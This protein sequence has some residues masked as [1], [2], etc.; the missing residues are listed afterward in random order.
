MLS[1]QSNNI[2]CQ[3]SIRIKLR[4]QNS[5]LVMVQPS[6]GA[7]LHQTFRVLWPRFFLFHPLKRA[8]SAKFC[9]YDVLGH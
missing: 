2:P 6:N 3:V 1:L 4:H 5:T 8:L 7:L 9:M